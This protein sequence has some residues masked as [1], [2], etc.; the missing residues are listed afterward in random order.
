MGFFNWRFAIALAQAGL[1]L[2]MNLISLPIIGDLGVFD[3]AD[4]LMSGL[5]AFAGG[6]N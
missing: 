4:I 6:S 3:A 5:L 2:L 1:E